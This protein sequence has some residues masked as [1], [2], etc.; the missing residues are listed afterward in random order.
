M[1]ILVDEV[2]CEIHSGELYVGLILGKDGHQSHHLILLP[3]EALRVSWQTAN[4]WAQDSGGDLPSRRELA[5][6]FAN[7]RECFQDRWYWSS[8]KHAADSF[9]AWNQFFGTGTQYDDHISNQMLA[10]A[11]RRM[12][13]R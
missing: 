6:L 11:V 13:I 12:S 1:M 2:R 3:G 4:Q 10:R 9:Y 8:E 7:R 5:L